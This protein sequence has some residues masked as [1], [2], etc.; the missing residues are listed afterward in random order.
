MDQGIDPRAKAK[1]DA[2]QGMTLR[3]MTDAYLKSRRSDPKRPMKQSSADEVNRHIDK[4]F[5]EW[6]DKPLKDIKRAAVQERYEQMRDHGLRGKRPAPGAAAQSLS[7]LNSVFRFACSRYWKDDDDTPLFTNPCTKV[8][9]NYSRALSL[10]PRDTRIPLDKVGAAWNALQTWRASPM[11]QMH[12]ANVD[13]AV[14]LLLTGARLNEGA[15]LTW[16]HVNLDEGWWHLPDPK[17]R[18][19]I[20]L[21]LSTQAAELLRERPRYSW[22]NQVFASR[23]AEDKRA[24]GPRYVC[25]KLWE[26]AG[27]PVSPTNP[28]RKLSPHDLRRTFCD[29]AEQKCDIVLTHIERLT[30]HVPSSTTEKHY[31]NTKEVQWLQ[32]DVQLIGN[33]IEEQG[34]IAS[35]A[36]VVALRA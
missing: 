13:L 31:L 34:K 28:T 5:A 10:E 36:N 9:E 32:P 23:L 19:P 17:N 1:E 20:W 15:L 16:N 22:T 33:W 14:F 12:R 29:I 6:R 18:R 26:V 11:T 27:K 25:Q 3:E 21:P 7:I 35:G 30:S 24:Q 2:T 4:T 8:I